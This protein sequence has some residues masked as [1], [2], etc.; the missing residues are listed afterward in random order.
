MSEQAAPG[1]TGSEALENFEVNVEA[2]PRD[3]NIE[4]VLLKRLK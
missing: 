4:V 2:L 3:T 1:G